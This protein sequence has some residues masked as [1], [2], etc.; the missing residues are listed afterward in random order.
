[1]KLSVRS[2]GIGIIH[3]MD[4]LQEC[5][6]DPFFYRDNRNKIRGQNM[7]CSFYK[8]YTQINCT[9]YSCNKLHHNI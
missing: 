5:D 4:L 7:G 8:I 9:I 6:E 2:I 3:Y 1:M